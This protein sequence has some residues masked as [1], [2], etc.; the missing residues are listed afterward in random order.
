M[1]AIA[2]AARTDLADKTASRR[3][4]VEARQPVIRNPLTGQP[5]PHARGKFT[6]PVNIVF[7]LSLWIS[8]SAAIWFTKGWIGLFFSGQL[9]SAG[10]YLFEILSKRTRYALFAKSMPAHEF[11]NGR[12]E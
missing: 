5:E 2:H 7:T 1:N 9:L 3:L 11:E 12:R 4:L 6:Y 10:A 8:L